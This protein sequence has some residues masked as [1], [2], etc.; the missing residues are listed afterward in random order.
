MSYTVLCFCACHKS[1]DQAG[2][3][4]SNNSLA[5]I[6]FGKGLVILGHWY[7]KRDKSNFKEGAITSY[8]WSFVLI[9]LL[10]LINQQKH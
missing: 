3:G 10:F 7:K 1:A 4:V 8:K 5:F 6:K 9:I 2:R